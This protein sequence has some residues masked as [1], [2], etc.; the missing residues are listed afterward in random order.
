MVRFSNVLVAIV[1]LIALIISFPII[2]IA[3]WFRLQPLSECERFLQFPLFAL[4]AFL[5]LVSVLGFIG[6]CFRISIFLWVY[7]FLIFLLILAT[8]IFSVFAVVITNKGVGEVVSG[9]GYEEYRLGDY[10][11]WLQKNVGDEKTWKVIE[12]CVKDAKVCGKFDREV[13]KK[14]TEFYNMNL[15]P[16]QLGCCKPPSFC[17]FTYVNSTNWAVPKSGFAS[18]DIDCKSWSNEQERLCYKCSSCKA[19]F[20]ATL[21]EG[22]KKIAIF[23]II[24]I[25]FLILMYSLGCC[26]FRNNKSHRP[27]KHY[28]RGAYP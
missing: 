21:K 15:S 7:L 16:M 19:G 9:R 11:N 1:N 14:A 26:A 20:I 25:V 23:N 27:P 18:S 5:F 4:G 17:G 10:S 6:S 28:Y 3:L 8:I 2:G 24:L 12:G 22:W 13:G